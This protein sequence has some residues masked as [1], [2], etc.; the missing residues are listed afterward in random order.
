MNGSPR[1]AVYSLGYVFFRRLRSGHLEEIGKVIQLDL[2][3][4]PAELSRQGGGVVGDLY[5]VFHGSLQDPGEA[6]I[7]ADDPLLV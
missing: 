4:H 6:T 7:E 3:T 2:A 1:R 5:P